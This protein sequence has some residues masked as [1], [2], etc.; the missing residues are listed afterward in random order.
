MAAIGQIGAG[1]GE[2]RNRMLEEQRNKDFMADLSA[3]LSRIRG[4]YNTPP[5]GMTG[6]EYWGYR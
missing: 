4:N 6:T 5:R 1:L 3:R 2:R